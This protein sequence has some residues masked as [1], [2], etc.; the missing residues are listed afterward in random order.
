MAEP[1]RRDLPR[2]HVLLLAVAF[3]VTLPGCQGYEFGTPTMHRFEIRSVHVPM[4]ESDSFR[5]FLGQRLTE[6]VVKEIELNT[7]FRVTSAAR[8]DSILTARIRKERKTPE[9]ES[10]FDDPRDL[11]YEMQVDVTWTDRGGIPLTDRQVLRLTRDVNF[12]PEGGQSLT[13]AQQEVI[14]RIARQI[15]NQMELTW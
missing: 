1:M 5:R 10:P 8:A 6:A 11:Q 7:P 13:S 3:L 9:I 14:E 12:I 4:I 2:Y 15:V